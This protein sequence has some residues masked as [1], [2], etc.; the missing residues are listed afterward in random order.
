MTLAAIAKDRLTGV[1]LVD[2]GPELSPAGMDVI[3]DYIGRNPPQ[4]TYEQA[5]AMRAQLLAGF[6]DVPDSRWAEEVRKHYNET[7]DGLQINY[8]PALRTAVLA[9]A[10][11]FV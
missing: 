9:T 1:C 3:K 8:D 4:K 11:A 2:I 6:E 10:T 7:P 5:A